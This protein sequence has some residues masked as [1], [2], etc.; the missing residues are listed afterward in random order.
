MS[1]VYAGQILKK[2]IVRM[3]RHPGGNDGSGSRDDGEQFQSSG[4][5]YGQ[6][7]IGNPG[8]GFKYGDD[9]RHK[10]VGYLESRRFR[11]VVLID[12]REH[13]FNEVHDIA[14]RKD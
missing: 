8:H 7:I 4:V 13:A 9:L 12:A 2:C 6:K 11:N 14:W 10:G 3:S 5:L 1:R